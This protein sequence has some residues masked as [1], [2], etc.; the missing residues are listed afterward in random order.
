MS[1]DEGRE[2]VLVVGEGQS[3]KTSLIKY[4][5]GYNHE[6]YYSEGD[7]QNRIKIKDEKTD[8]NKDYGWK[9]IDT[10]E[11]FN[12]REDLSLK[13]K[14]NDIIKCIIFVTS[15]DICRY[16]NMF[17]NI[18]IMEKLFKDNIPFQLNSI[19]LISNNLIDD[20][21]LKASKEK[22]RD[23]F[24][25]YMIDSLYNL[26]DNYKS[27]RTDDEFRIL[28]DKFEQMAKLFELN[29]NRIISIN[30]TDPSYRELIHKEID[31]STCISP[32]FI[33]DGVWKSKLETQ[34]LRK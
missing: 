14:K 22:I 28:G 25:K 26:S 6:H 2:V 12:N 23:I 9:Y 24:N 19:L 4:L 20:T 10:Y 18:K 16:Q 15:V 34:Y 33:N 30:I 5:E 17:N 13:I 29:K 1:S 8:I 11:F 32:T 21:F 31:K 27:N 3:G 7:V